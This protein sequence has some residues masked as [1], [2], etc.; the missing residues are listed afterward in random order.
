M[1]RQP[2][3][4]SVNA[5][6]NRTKEAIDSLY[7]HRD[8]APGCNNLPAVGTPTHGIQPPRSSHDGGIILQ[9]RQQHRHHSTTTT[10][11]TTSSVADADD[12][13]DAS[14]GSVDPT[15]VDLSTT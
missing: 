1:V 13:D 8:V 4:P 6:D 9:K 10:T 3:W 2:L 15:P 7:R 14:S 12:A 5:V 11:T